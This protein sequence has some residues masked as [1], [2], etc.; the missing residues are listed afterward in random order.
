MRRMDRGTVATGRGTRRPYDRG[1]S[2][3]TLLVLLL[4]GLLA[5]IP[6]LRLR[7]AAWRSSWLQTAWFG[8]FLL[9][10]M[11]LAA[12]S[13]GRFLAP[14]LLILFVLPFVIGTDR[15]RRLARRPA[16]QSNG[17]VIDVTP[18]QPDATAETGTDS[19]A[20]RT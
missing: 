10:A 20:P 7:M 13:T 5:L 12:P 15:L 3:T 8:Y 6:V 16:R 9:L 11:I 4:A 18:R 14:V 1:V 17:V 19:G 2:P